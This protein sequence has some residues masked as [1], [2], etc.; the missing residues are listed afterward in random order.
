MNAD[1][2]GSRSVAYWVGV[3]VRPPILHLAL[4]K[5]GGKQPFA[6]AISNVGLFDLVR[7]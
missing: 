6:A 5:K 7:L 3:Q 1:S 2:K 4:G